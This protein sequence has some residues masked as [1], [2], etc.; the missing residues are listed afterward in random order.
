M[1]VGI[2][3]VNVMVHK[4]IRAEKSKKGYL[5]FASYLAAVIAAVIAANTKSQEAI[6]SG[7]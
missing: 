3:T 5:R 1:H 7:T 4:H 2:F 6:E